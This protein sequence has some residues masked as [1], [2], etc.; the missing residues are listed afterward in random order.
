MDATIVVGIPA[1]NSQHH[2]PSR[3]DLF[4]L[5]SMSTG[6]I[7]KG[8]SLFDSR[9][10]KWKPLVCWWMERDTNMLFRISLLFLHFPPSHFS[11]PLTTIV[12]IILFPP[13]FSFMNTLS[14]VAHNSHLSTRPSWIRGCCLPLAE[15][16]SAVSASRI[17]VFRYRSGVGRPPAKE[18]RSCASASPVSRYTSFFAFFLF[19]VTHNPLGAA[20]GNN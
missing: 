20:I 3:H 19:S 17:Y 4:R 15:S 6:R 5:W 2:G 10:R 13:F 12:F 11:L 7:D 9:D 1:T 8:H 18:S 16:F 14:M